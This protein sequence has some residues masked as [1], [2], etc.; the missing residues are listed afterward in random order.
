MSC[1]CLRRAWARESA[2]RKCLSLALAVIKTGFA[3]LRALRELAVLGFL[4]ATS[5]VNS[6]DLLSHSGPGILL[7]L[8]LALGDKAFT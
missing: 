4:A 7:D 8:G 3:L 6:L 1:V 5:F 2:R